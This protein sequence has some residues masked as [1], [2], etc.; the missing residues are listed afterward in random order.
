MINLEKIEIASNVEIGDW[1]IVVNLG[2][3]IL[4]EDGTYLKSFDSGLF[5]STK[6]AGEK[7]LVFEIGKELDVSEKLANFFRKNWTPVYDI[8]PFE[9]FKNQDFFRSPK[10]KFG[11]LELNF[12]YCGEDFSCGIHNEHN[13]FEVHAQILGVGEMQKFRS[14]EEDSIY[15][16]ERLTP[17]GTHK[18]FFNKNMQ[19]PYHQYKSI[20]KCIWL[21]I[22]SSKVVKI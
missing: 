1:S 9:I 17:G 4:L 14:E 5:R 8:F 18:P 15:Y 10:F 20:S 6:I 21:A 3:K 11:D 19:Y 2:G 13:F 7:L 22:E 16:K 12:W